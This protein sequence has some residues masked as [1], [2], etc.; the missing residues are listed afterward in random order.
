MQTSCRKWICKKFNLINKLYKENK[1]A[2]MWNLAC[3]SKGNKTSENAIN[4]N[5]LKEHFRVKFDAVSLNKTQSEALDT[6]N[7]K[8]DAYHLLLS[9]TKV[10][11]L[12]KLINIAT[13]YT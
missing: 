3:K 8:Y 11:G 6:V 9:S 4:M 12:E 5:T 1:T 2:R 13:T 10:T 7:I